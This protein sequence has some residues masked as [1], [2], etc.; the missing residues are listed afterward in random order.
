MLKLT[1]TE[2]SR[3]DL[4]GAGFACRHSS[5]GIRRTRHGR[6]P[7]HPGT[8]RGD[9]RRA[10]LL[11]L[12]PETKTPR[13]HRPIDVSTSDMALLASA[14]GVRQRA[15][16]TVRRGE[17]A[18]DGGRRRR[19]DPSGGGR[20]RAGFRSTSRRSWPAAHSFRWSTTGASRLLGI[21]CNTRA[22]VSNRRC[23]RSS[24]LFGS[25]E[26]EPMTTSVPDQ[27]LLVLENRPFARLR[28]KP[29]AEIVQCGEPAP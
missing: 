3:L 29:V 18:A 5:G 10:E 22:A 13:V 16:V 21:Y 27:E 23:Q 6:G 7:G 17:W 15:E 1:T 19:V 11:R 26:R 20:R 25:R 2:E 14:K 24:K 9:R 28:G 8:A 12:V 4:V